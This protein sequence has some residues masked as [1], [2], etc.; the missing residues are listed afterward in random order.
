MSELRRPATKPALLAWA[1]E[2]LQEGVPQWTVYLRLSK[3]QS[4]SND[5]REM[6]VVSKLMESIE[7]IIV[8]RNLKGTQLEKDGQEDKAIALYEANISDRFD[9]SHPYNRLRILYKNRGDYANAIR[10]CEAYIN[11]EGSD[12]KLC[13]SFRAEIAKLQTK[14][15]K[16]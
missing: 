2:Q 3:M 14:F 5:V 13:E 4:E 6:Q 16:A 11:N 10:V 8:D 9:G 15:F 1:N 12:G 7:D